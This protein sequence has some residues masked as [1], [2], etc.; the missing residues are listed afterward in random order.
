[1]VLFY[2][3]GNKNISKVHVTNLALYFLQTVFHAKFNLI[4]KI[5]TQDSLQT[6]TIGFKDIENITK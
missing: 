6:D 1:M 5:Q 4:D 2:T 3:T